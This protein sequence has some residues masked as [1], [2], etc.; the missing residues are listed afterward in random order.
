MNA[1]DRTAIYGTG[2]FFVMSSVLLVCLFDIGADLEILP[3]SLL[4]LAFMLSFSSIPLLLCWPIF[5][6]KT[7]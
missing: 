4:V 6:R 5:Q 2:V 3:L 7:K 1:Q